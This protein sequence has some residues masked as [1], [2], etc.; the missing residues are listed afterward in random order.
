VLLNQGVRPHPTSDLKQFP[1]FPQQSKS[2]FLTLQIAAVL[3]MAHGIE[4]VSQVCYRVVDG[5][6]QQRLAVV[7][8]GKAHLSSLSIASLS[9]HSLSA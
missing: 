8:F 7:C 1:V 2:Q 5:T 9:P 3:S 4:R 6:A